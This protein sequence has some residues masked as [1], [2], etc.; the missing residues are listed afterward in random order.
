MNPDRAMALKT[1]VRS[2]AER[3]K[4]NDTKIRSRDDLSFKKL[5][6][7]CSNTR[8]SEITTNKHSKFCEDSRT[9]I[10]TRYEGKEQDLHLLMT[11]R[12]AQSIQTDEYKN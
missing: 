6:E 10:D 1:Q 8:Q 5:G 7:K 12:R 4:G 9:E 3:N 11:L 2:Y